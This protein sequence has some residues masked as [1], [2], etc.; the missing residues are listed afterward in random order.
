MAFLQLIFNI[1][2]AGGNA[3]LLS[4]RVL[5]LEV[6]TFGCWWVSVTTGA[7]SVCRG[8][9]SS[10]P[11]CRSVVSLILSLEYVGY[12]I[13]EFDCLTADGMSRYGST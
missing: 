6:M 13:K 4:I 1:V 10:L 3:Q 7:L 2:K 11:L 9:A 12:F 5:G 8:G